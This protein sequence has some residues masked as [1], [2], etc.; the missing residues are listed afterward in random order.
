M[1]GHS[2]TR[3][4]HVRLSQ[5]PNDYWKFQLLIIINQVVSI[6]QEKCNNYD[7]ETE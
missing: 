5:T 1:H 4:L 6:Y 3:V 2:T 7:S